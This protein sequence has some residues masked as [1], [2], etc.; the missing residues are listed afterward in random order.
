MLPLPLV[1][2]I[3][4]GQLSAVTFAEYQAIRAQGDGC[5]YKYG[6]DPAL[7]KHE[8]RRGHDRNDTKQHGGQARASRHLWMKG[9]IMSWKDLGKL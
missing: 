1:M 3:L 7:Q 8:R 6:K 5:G 4:S 9:E 2:L